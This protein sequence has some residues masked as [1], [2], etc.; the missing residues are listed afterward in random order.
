M[1]DSYEIDNTKTAFYKIYLII[2]QEHDKMAVCRIEQGV[3]TFYDNS[4]SV[5]GKIKTPFTNYQAG[6]GYSAI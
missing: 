4:A 3:I 5:G 2:Q 1:L 6:D